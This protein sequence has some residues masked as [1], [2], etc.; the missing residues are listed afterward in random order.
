MLI[1]TGILL[2]TAISMQFTSEVNWG[3]EDFVVMGFMLAAAGVALETSL[4]LSKTSVQ[5]GLAIGFIAFSFVAI[6]TELAVGIF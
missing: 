2:A 3:P 1:A 4:R 5:K 6:W